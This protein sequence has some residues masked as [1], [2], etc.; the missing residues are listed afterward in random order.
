VS[1]PPYW[2]IGRDEENW[3]LF[4]VKDGSVGINVG[5]F[6]NPPP[7]SPEVRDILIAVQMGCTST[8]TVETGKIVSG[9]HLW[10]TRR[11]SCQ[12][13]KSLTLAIYDTMIG[14]VPYYVVLANRP[15]S[16]WFDTVESEVKR[17]LDSMRPFR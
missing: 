8:G 12:G 5:W 17:M 3:V 4:D 9:A 1:Y 13:Q 16:S 10:N 11:F 15:D 6:T 14:G 7:P 2:K